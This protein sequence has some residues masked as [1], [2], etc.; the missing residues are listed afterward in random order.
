M[1]KRLLLFLFTFVYCFG[2]IARTGT[3]TGL[4]NNGGTGNLTHSYTATGGTNGVLLVSVAGA[5]V[6]SEPDDV[7]GVTFNGVTA[8]LIGKF[9]RDSGRFQYAY[10]LAAP[11]SGAHNVVVTASTNHY[12]SA[13][14]SEYTGADQSCAPD[15]RI[16][17]AAQSGTSFTGT[18]TTFVANDWTFLFGMGYSGGSAPSAGSGASLVVADGGD[19]IA[20]IFDSNGVINPAGSKSMTYTYPSSNPMS[21]IMFALAP[22]GSGVT[23]LASVTGDWSSTTTWGGCGPPG[24]GKRA[25]I[26]AAVTVTVTGATTIGNS[27]TDCSFLAIRNEGSLVIA[28]GNTLHM[29]GCGLN[30]G[31][32]ALTINGTGV[33]EFD[34]SAA[35]G[36][37]TVHYTW[38]NNAA[39]NEATLITLAGTDLSNRATIQSN[40]GGGNGSITAGGFL[41]G[42][43]VVCTYCE[44]LRVGTA[45]IDAIT[46]Y[47]SN[48]ANVFSLN[49]L[50]CDTCGMINQIIAG[51]NNANVKLTNSTWV[52]S[53]GTNV[54]ALSGS[55]SDGAGTHVVSGDVFDI[56]PSWPLVEGWSITNNYFTTSWAAQGGPWVLFDTAFFEEDQ[57]ASMHG[58]VSN[59][60]MSQRSTKMNPHYLVHDQA[61]TVVV[62]GVIFED[63]GAA[64]DGDTVQVAGSISNPVTVQ[65]S[66]KLPNASGNSSGTAFTCGCSTSSQIAIN[67]NTYFLGGDRESSGIRYGETITP[68]PGMFTSIKSNAF[69]DT[70]ARGWKFLCIIPTCNTSSDSNVV[71]GAN[72]D[73]N[74]GSSS[75]FLAGLAGKGYDSTFTVA[76]GAHDLD[77]DPGFVDRTR[78]LIAYDKFCGGAGTEA[79]AIAGF[80][81][82]NSAS[83]NSCY[84]ITKLLNWVRQGFA[85]QNVAFATA[86]HDGGRIGAVQPVAILGAVAQ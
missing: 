7:T 15:A 44:L 11:A 58:S 68:G 71:A 8:T 14:V 41:Q 55:A 22:A 20:S 80:K 35:S 36:P 86:G 82:R 49:Y 83:W 56:I 67:K 53:T 33:L 30:A 1:A 62:D 31:A 70:S 72:A 25:L 18:L 26:N 9:N 4:G 24:D 40:S 34:A 43:M 42:G 21:G 73:Y 63:L 65:N 16:I 13:A 64:Q 48:S 66:I 45:S 38:Q 5:I 50:L 12:L 2:A 3:P 27:L 81:A 19:N 57:D 17:Q 10:C 59:F 51:D 60:Y 79:S 54:F 39:D 84:D 32:G 46:F 75:Q 47:P 37:S 69:W 74:G 85:P 29:R 6:G 76:P 23:C 77:A 61:M 52:N 28:S 78:G